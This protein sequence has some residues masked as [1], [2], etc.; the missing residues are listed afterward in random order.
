METI[1]GES[2]AIP[3]LDIL[4]IQILN[5]RDGVLTAIEQ[6]EER[7]LR[8]GDVETG[9]HRVRGKIRGFYFA[10][11]PAIKRWLK[12]D[13][14]DIMKEKMVESYTEALIAFRKIN[15]L[16]DSKHIT[17][18]DMEKSYDQTSIEE[19]NSMKGV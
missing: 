6:H 9:S 13:E 10:L 1:K 2:V 14:Y 8:T 11:E 3:P 17:R 4:K 12:K 15:E 5:R 16:L 19:E 18:I 7:A